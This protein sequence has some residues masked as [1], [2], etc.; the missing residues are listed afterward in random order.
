[1]NEALGPQAFSSV[2]TFGLGIIPCSFG[3]YMKDHDTPLSVPT[4]G[5]DG[6]HSYYG[7]TS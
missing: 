1:M 7:S 2:F 6:R 3:R 4:A 5:D